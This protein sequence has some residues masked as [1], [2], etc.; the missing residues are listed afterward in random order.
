MTARRSGVVLRLPPFRNF[1]RPAC[2]T[3]YMDT[4]LRKTGN[5]GKQ[6]LYCPGQYEFVSL[7][8]VGYIWDNRVADE[9]VP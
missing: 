2:K 7:L 9:H 1:L 5:L 8:E 6:N 4:C 3:F